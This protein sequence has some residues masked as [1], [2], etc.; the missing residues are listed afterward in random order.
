MLRFYRW[1][2]HVV[3][4]MENNLDWEEIS[5]IL[6]DWIRNKLSGKIFP[7]LFL[8]SLSYAWIVSASFV[9]REKVEHKEPAKDDH[10]NMNEA[11]TPSFSVEAST[12]LPS[13]ALDAFSVPLVLTIW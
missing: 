9:A 4:R 1:L 13:S 6:G 2:K 8:Y 11:K 3:K 7:R 5:S 12:A 10:E